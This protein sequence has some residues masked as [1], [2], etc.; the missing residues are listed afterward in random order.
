MRPPQLTLTTDN[1]AVLPVTELSFLFCLTPSGDDS[2]AC[3][4]AFCP[5]ASLLVLE[6]PCL[7]AGKSVFPACFLDFLLFFFLSC[8]P[9]SSGWPGFDTRK[10]RKKYTNQD[11]TTFSINNVQLQL[12]TYEP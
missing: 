6:T 3:G 10:K 8:L 12:N 5:G 1:S 11:N 2:L 9:A 7:T 4:A